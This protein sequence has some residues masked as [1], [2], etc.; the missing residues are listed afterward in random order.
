MVF[1]ISPAEVYICTQY[2]TLLYM[3]YVHTSPAPICHHHASQI[4]LYYVVK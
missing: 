4:S 2:Y 1:Y 3:P